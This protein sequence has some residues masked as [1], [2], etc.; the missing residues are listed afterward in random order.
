MGAINL[1]LGH[2]TQ[3]VA[4]ARDYYIKALAVCRENTDPK[5]LMATLCSFGHLAGP[6]QEYAQERAYLLECLELS[7]ATDDKRLFSYAMHNLGNIERYEGNLDRAEELYEKS[8]R[9]KQELGDSWATAY[10][11][12]GSAA[13]A[14]ARE[15]GERAA[16]LFG[17]AA[18]I[19][20]RLGAPL[21]PSKRAE[22][23][24]NLASARIL[25]APESFEAAWKEGQAFSLSEAVDYVCSDKLSAAPSLLP[26]DEF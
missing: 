10:T 3:D 22:Y 2:I 23:D 25:L 18:A 24:D 15:Q 21:E 17:A 16:R 14:V 19:R 20:K 5:P 7:E 8:I 6:G 4:E 13:L 1:L 11:L 9:L 26:H 12:E